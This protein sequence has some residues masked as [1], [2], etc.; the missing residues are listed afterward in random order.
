MCVLCVYYR[1]QFQKNKHIT[2]VLEIIYLLG[3]IRAMEADA[4]KYQAYK[5]NSYI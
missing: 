4:I 5:M 3:E 1:P 2:C